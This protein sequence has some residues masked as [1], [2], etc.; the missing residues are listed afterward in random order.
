MREPYQVLVL[1]YNDDADFQVCVFH[2]KTGDYWQFVAGGKESTDETLI[3]TVRREVW[4]E[5]GLSI[6]ADEIVSL[7]TV[8]SVPAYFFRNKLSADTILVTEHSF[9][10]YIRDLHSISLSREH[11]KY[12]VA[13]Y[14]SAKALLR[15]DSNK[16]ALYELRTKLERQKMAE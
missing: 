7:E 3:E 13:D 16:T 6:T 5:A 1:L 2:R 8:A 14:E 15:W 11:D 9:A 4:E 12:L 10:V